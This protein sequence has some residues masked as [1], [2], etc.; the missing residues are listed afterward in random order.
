MLPLALS[1][2]LTACTQVSIDSPGKSDAAILADIKSCGAGSFHDRAVINCLNSR[3]DTITYADGTIPPYTAGNPYDVPMTAAEVQ[4]RTAAATAVLERW[5]A[6]ARESAQSAGVTAQPSQQN[7]DGINVAPPQSSVPSQR[8]SQDN[9]APESPSAPASASSQ[10]TSTASAGN[11]DVTSQDKPGLLERVATATQNL[12]NGFRDYETTKTSTE[13]A[14]F[15]ISFES[16]SVVNITTLDSDIVLKNIIIDKT[17][18][19]P[20]IGVYHFGDDDYH[21]NPNPYHSFRP[22]AMN[23]G[24]KLRILAFD[25]EVTEQALDHSKLNGDNILGATLSGRHDCTIYEMEID[26]NKGAW[27][28]RFHQ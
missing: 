27:S 21:G 16:H 9:S 25:R 15:E 22:V 13:E 12:A 24:D 7:P 20:F 19:N 4:R 11:E 10:P 28:Y 5:K 6:A 8:V 2:I 17:H 23:Y 14:P 3:G 26:T 1:F 18:C